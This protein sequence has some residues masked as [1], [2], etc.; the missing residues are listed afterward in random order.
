MYSLLH[1]VFSS[2]T[3]SGIFC[4]ASNSA[5][6]TSEEEQIIEKEYLSGS[7]FG[8]SEVGAET[9]TKADEKEKHASDV[10]LEYLPGNRRMKKKNSGS[11]K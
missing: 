3:A 11:A 9:S 6:Q 10:E 5:P 8:G 2:S 1:V 7:E 4:N